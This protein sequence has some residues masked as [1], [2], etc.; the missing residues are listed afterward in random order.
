MDE[1]KCHIRMGMRRIT[2]SMKIIW[3]EN[4]WLQHH[5]CSIESL[6]FSKHMS[7]PGVGNKVDGDHP[8]HWLKRWKQTTAAQ[9]EWQHA[10]T[11]IIMS[12]WLKCLVYDT[13]DTKDVNLTHHTCMNTCCRWIDAHTLYLKVSIYI[14]SYLGIGLNPLSFTFATLHSFNHIGHDHQILVT[15]ISQTKWCS[16]GGCG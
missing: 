8:W 3:Q 2:T 13:G 9:M 4:E 7:C 16:D 5:Y 12:F 14:S 15:P 1:S 10:S 6:R 11:S